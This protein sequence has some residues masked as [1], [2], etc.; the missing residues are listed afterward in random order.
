MKILHKNFIFGER[1]TRK[2]EGVIIFLFLQAATRFVVHTCGI[3]MMRRLIGTDLLI[4][5]SD[6]HQPVERVEQSHSVSLGHR[7][8]GRDAVVREG[9]KCFQASHR[10]QHHLVRGNPCQ[11]EPDRNLKRAS[12]PLGGHR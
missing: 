2:R 7:D 6:Q 9:C 12:L 10:I 1:I 11:K 5:A 8:M 4:K 3:A